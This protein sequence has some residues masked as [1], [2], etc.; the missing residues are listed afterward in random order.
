ML[1]AEQA[2]EREQE[3]SKSKK[4]ETFIS[5][6]T[7]IVGAFLGRKVVSASSAGSLGTAMRSASRMRKEKM[8]VARAH[9]IA[10]SVKLEMADLEERL[11]TEIGG[12]EATFDIADEAIQE[13]L[14]KPK[15]TDITLEIYGL[16]WM[17][18]RRDASGHLAPDWI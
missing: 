16:V 6:G 18:Y 4:V 13:V 14:V 1:R 15:S 5:F 8:D 9:E 3:Q 10:E 12:L 7:A 2:I 17:P 11:Q